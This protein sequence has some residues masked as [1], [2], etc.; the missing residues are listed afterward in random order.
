LKELEKR[1]RDCELKH[2][3][4]PD[5]FLSRNFGKPRATVVHNWEKDLMRRVRLEGDDAY[6]RMS[7]RAKKVEEADEDE[8]EKVERGK[9]EKERVDK[10]ERER[11]ERIE[12]E[13]AKQVERG[14]MERNKWKRVQKNRRKRGIWK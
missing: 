1:R 13:G 10:V 8:K 12:K 6:T 5:F 4:L 2:D 3:P 14:I 7:K 11:V 9:A